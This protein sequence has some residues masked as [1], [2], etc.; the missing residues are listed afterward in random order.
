V[1]ASPWEQKFLRKRRYM[2]RYRKIAEIFSLG[3]CGGGHGG[4]YG[5]GYGGGYGDSECHFHY[6]NS[7]GSYSGGH[8][9]DRY[10]SHNGG[11]LLGIFGD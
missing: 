2:E 7:Y 8:H 1:D 4:G 9:G 6:G 5:R 3:G 11:G 10:E